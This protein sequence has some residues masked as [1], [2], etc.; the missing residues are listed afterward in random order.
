MAGF[1][2][3]HRVFK[4]ASAAYDDD[5]GAPNSHALYAPSAK[6]NGSPP[7]TNTMPA[8]TPYRATMS[9]PSGTVSSA[10]GWL[11]HTAAPTSAPAAAHRPFAS[12]VTARRSAV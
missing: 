12:A 4:P 2:I 6:A 3:A 7:A 1:G 9:P 8:R 10:R 11:S 5:H